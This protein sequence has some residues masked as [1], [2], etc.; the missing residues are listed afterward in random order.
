MKKLKL[1]EILLI[2][3]SSDMHYT[4]KRKPGIHSVA[5]TEG[6]ENKHN[7]A[8][9][10]IL[11]QWFRYFWFECTLHWNT[12]LFSKSNWTNKSDLG[13]E[14]A[15]LTFTCSKSTIETLEKGMKYVQS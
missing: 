10:R 7:C 11:F 5:K 2:S 1:S 13:E 6:I 14:V 9:Y 12:K 3:G 4:G 15:Q 8:K